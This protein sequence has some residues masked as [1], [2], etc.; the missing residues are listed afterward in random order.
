MMELS[1]VGGWSLRGGYIC[2][3]LLLFFEGGYG[4]KEDDSGGCVV[5]VMVVW[6]LSLYVDMVIPHNGSSVYRA[7]VLVEW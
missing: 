4:A 3:S 5:M 2:S 6:S 7:M 1:V